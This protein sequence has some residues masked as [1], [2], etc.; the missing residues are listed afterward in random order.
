MHEPGQRVTPHGLAGSRSAAASS[1]RPLMQG[2]L[3]HPRAGP[4]VPPHGRPQ[5]HAPPRRRQPPGANACVRTGRAQPLDLRRPPCRR[6]PTSL[7]PA[8][9][10]LACA[11]A[12]CSPSPHALF[13]HRRCCPRLGPS[14]RA[15]APRPTALCG[16]WPG[17]T[18]TSTTWR[19]W[20]PRACSSRSDGVTQTQAGALRRPRR[21]PACSSCS[22][23]E[24]TRPP[25]AMNCCRPFGFPLLPE[26]CMPTPPAIA[27]PCPGCALRPG[28]VCNRPCLTHGGWLLYTSNAQRGRRGAGREHNGSVWAKTRR[29]Q[30]GAAQAGP[31]ATQ[32]PAARPPRPWPLRRSRARD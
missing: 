3:P 8:C 19:R 30:A 21:P 14:T 10:H 12:P 29:G 9:P 25:N 18:R 20:R 15:R 7:P 2:P 22:S 13:S 4:R 5:R 24:A 26:V 11:R 17:R 23:D 1:S 31:P 6:Q 16:S 32:P 27:C 28:R